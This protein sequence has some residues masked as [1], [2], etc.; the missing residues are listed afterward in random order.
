MEGTGDETHG[1][2]QLHIKPDLC[3][4]SVTRPGCSTLQLVTDC[5]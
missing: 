1:R 4:Q 5:G 3:E 2:V